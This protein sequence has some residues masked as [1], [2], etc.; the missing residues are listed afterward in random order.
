MPSETPLS[1][2][3]G[4]R[5]PIR[6]RDRVQVAIVINQLATPGLGSWLAGRRIAGAGQLILAFAGF[7]LFVGYLGILLVG[8]WRATWNGLEPVPPNPA[9]WRWGIG[10]FGAAWLWAAVT[11]LQLWLGLRRDREPPTVEPPRLS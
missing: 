3:S 8:V 7:F 6:R 11:S 5:W 10:L 1:V 4:I 9:W 2:R